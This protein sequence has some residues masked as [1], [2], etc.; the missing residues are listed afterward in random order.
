MNHLYEWIFYLN[1]LPYSTPC[2]KQLSDHTKIDKNSNH[3]QF[4]Q[5]IEFYVLN[6][7]IS[8]CKQREGMHTC[9]MQQYPSIKKKI[10]SYSLKGK[11]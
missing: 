6:Q 9:N 11:S 3:S 5:N 8:R 2:L 4:Q 7:L 1:A 10:L